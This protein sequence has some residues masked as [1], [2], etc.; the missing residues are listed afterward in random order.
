[1][2]TRSRNNRGTKGSN[3]KVPMP[4]VSPE[5]L[6]YLELLVPE[7][8]PAQEQSRDSIMWYAGR[9]SLVKELYRRAQEES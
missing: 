5:F 4:Y 3:K 2:N 1:M 9:R 6:E 8:I 7:V